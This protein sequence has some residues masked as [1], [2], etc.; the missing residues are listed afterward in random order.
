[1]HVSVTNRKD[2]KRAYISRLRVYAPYDCIDDS[3]SLTDR[4]FG[5]GG[6]DDEDDDYG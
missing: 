5:N 2:E 4:H 3:S 6:V 1:M